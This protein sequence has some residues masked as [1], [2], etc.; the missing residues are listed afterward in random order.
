MDI[1]EQFNN[2][3]RTMWQSLRRLGDIN[4]EIVRRLS[5]V[6][7]NA[8][9]LSIEGG[10]EQLKLAT[11]KPG[12]S[13]YVAAQAELGNR[14]GSKLAGV[15]REVSDI[16]NDGREEAVNW[17]EGSISDLQES[18]TATARQ[19]MAATATATATAAATPTDS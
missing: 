8:I 1:L 10:T 9:N 16:V 7:I 14:Y 6:Q 5:E 17:A 13:D 3:G 12:Y 2:N 15:M 18:T 19:A 4:S 11:A